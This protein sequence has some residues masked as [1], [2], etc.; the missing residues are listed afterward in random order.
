M[1][2]PLSYLGLFL[3]ICLFLCSVATVS[4]SA[5]KT[6]VPAPTSAPTVD[7]HTSTSV[8][9]TEVAGCEYGLLSVGTSIPQS[10]LGEIVVEDPW[11]ESDDGI[12]WQSSPQ[13]TGLTAGHT[14]T[15][16]LRFAETATTMASP[17]SPALV[18]E[19]QEVTSVPGDVNGD[20]K[21]NVPDRALLARYLAN[22]AGY[23]QRINMD[24]ADV[25]RDK[26]VSQRDRM[27]LSRYLSNWTGYAK[28]FTK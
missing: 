11:G 16:Y 25:D 15:F 26:K 21:V 28:Y 13:F 23:A 4:V 12:L 2:R 20:G 8:F 1:K 9:L 3:S 18:Y 22:W 7:T 14:Y 10:E 19:L 27:L 6:S 5:A 24:N 17:I